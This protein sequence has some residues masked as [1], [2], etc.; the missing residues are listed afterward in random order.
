[1]S[2]IA[3]HLGEQRTAVHSWKT[4]DKWDAASPVEKVEIA[5][6]TRLA[7]LIARTEKDGRDF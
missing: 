7:L 1:M 6:E 4:R 5:L 3:R 2:S